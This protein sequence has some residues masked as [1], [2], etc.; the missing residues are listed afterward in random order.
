MRGPERKGN[1]Y[2]MAQSKSGLSEWGKL[3]WEKSRVSHESR[4]VQ[5]FHLRVCCLRSPAAASAPAT[6][7]NSIS[8]NM[9]THQAPPT[10]YLNLV[11][12]ITHCGR[13]YL[14]YERPSHS[15]PE[16]NVKSWQIKTTGVWLPQNWNLHQLSSS[17]TLSCANFNYI[18]MGGY[19]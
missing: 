1:P 2:V 14:V 6:K 19:Q 10:S 18:Q 13:E 15:K 17:G 7:E 11:E 8:F 3:V 12:G 5:T 16:V 4:L 9:P